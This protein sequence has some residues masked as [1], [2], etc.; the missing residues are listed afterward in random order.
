MTRFA[1]VSD[2]GSSWAALI[3]GDNAVPLDGIIEL[4]V[5]TLLTVLR[6][7]PQRR[8]GAIPVDEVALCP[9]IPAPERALC[10][11]L[12]YSEHI[13]E[14]HRDAPTPQY[15]SRSSRAL[16]S[17]PVPDTAPAGVQGA[18]LGGQLAAGVCVASDVSMRDHQRKTHQ[19]VQGKAWD[20]S[21]PFGPEQV[22]IDD[23]G[24]GGGLE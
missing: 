19:W 3:G 22:T 13:D 8:R 17:A 11:G 12:N 6:D 24:D 10:V 18:R 21:T 23:V 16:S 2:E 9:L 15:S 20:G 7:P 5:H 1:S 4:G 14:T